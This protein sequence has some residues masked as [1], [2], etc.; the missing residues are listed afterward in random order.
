MIK[1]VHFVQVK[2]VLYNMSTL[3]IQ[4]LYFCCLCAHMYVTTV[5]MCETLVNLLLLYSQMMMAKSPGT[6]L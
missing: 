5:Y 3:C 4:I 1:V 6:L 2:M